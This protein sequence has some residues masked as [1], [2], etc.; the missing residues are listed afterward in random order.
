[1]T[2]EGMAE[3][4]AALRRLPDDLAGEAGHIVEAAANAA[5]AEVRQGYQARLKGHGRQ[6]GRLVGGVSVSRFEAGRAAAAAVLKSDAPHAWMFEHGTQARHTDLGANRGAMPPA[7]V[8][9]PAAMR[10]RA[11]MYEE[12]AALVRRAGLEVT[13]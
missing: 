5:A 3:L 7:H 12:L 11:R 8:F 4:R 6:P 2:W 13:P 9:V 1:M 10:V